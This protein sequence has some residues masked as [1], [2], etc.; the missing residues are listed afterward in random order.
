MIFVIFI[1]GCV[2]VDKNH[3]AW[4][5]TECESQD[6]LVSAGFTLLFEVCCECEDGSLIE[7]DRVSFDHYPQEIYE[8]YRDDENYEFQ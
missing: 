2:S 1:S 7:H 5:L 3:W 8:I 6:G 4:C